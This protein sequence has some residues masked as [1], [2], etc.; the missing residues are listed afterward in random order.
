[1]AFGDCHV[2]WMRTPVIGQNGDN[3]WTS[4][5]PGSPSGVSSTGIPVDPSGGNI[6]ATHSNSDVAP[7]DIVMVPIRNV[8][9]G[10]TR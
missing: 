6:P 9:N 7:F 3:I 8:S 10:D 2:E 5:A 4:A 1:V